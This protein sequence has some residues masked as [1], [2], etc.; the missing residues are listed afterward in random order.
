MGGI[1]DVKFYSMWSKYFDLNTSYRQIRLFIQPYWRIVLAS[2]LFITILFFVA[3]VRRC[4]NTDREKTGVIERL[5][6]DYKQIF[7]ESYSHIFAD[8]NTLHL[9]AAQTLQPTPFKGALNEQE[10][11]L[12]ALVETNPF[13]KV[14]KL[15]HSI[16]YLVPEAKMLL[17]HIGEDFN[18]ALETKGIPAY[19]IIVT[20]LTRTQDQQRKL[21]HKNINAATESSHSYGTTF[22]IAWS[23]FDK[24]DPTAQDVSDADLKRV[25]ASILRQ[26]QKARRCYIKHEKRQACFH[27][28]TIK[29]LTE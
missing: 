25:L 2:V 19:R 10:R 21:S 27:I 13:Y 26:Y 11:S 20:S 18:I 22:D 4:S 7:N 3:I 8:N 5:T 15:T 9:Q 12:L 17:D 16:P 23:R 1:E 28:T 6:I 14:D 29:P 24:V